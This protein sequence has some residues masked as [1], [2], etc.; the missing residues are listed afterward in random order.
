MEKMVT[1]SDMIALTISIMLIITAI[2]CGY[3]LNQIRD[4]VREIKE[5]QKRLAEKLGVR[6]R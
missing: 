2:A 4:I 1:A 3:F 6:A 5:T